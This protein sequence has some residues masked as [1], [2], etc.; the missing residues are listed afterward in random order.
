MG[1]RHASADGDHLTPTAILKLI[2]T[3]FGLE[4]L[5]ERDKNSEDMTPALDFAKPPEKT[6]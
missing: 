6:P 5:G 3:R 2:E 1:S 4:P